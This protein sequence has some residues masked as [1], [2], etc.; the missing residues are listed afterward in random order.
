VGPSSGKLRPH[1]PRVGDPESSVSSGSHFVERGPSPRFEEKPRIQAGGEVGTNPERYTGLGGPT[2]D[3][4]RR[5]RRGWRD[6]GP[7]G[8]TADGP[9]R[10]RNP[11]RPDERG[12]R[13]PPSSLALATTPQRGITDP[14]TTTFF[15]VL[16]GL[17]GGNDFVPHFGA[18]HLAGPGLSTAHE[19]GP[20]AGDGAAG[21]SGEAGIGADERSVAQAWPRGAGQPAAPGT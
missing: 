6:R 2:T 8:Q 9:T 20:R 4:R 13:V 11:A 1:P 5:T 7:V 19:G 10:T 18:R 16:N 14:L 15:A 21:N 3:S 12:D 17:S